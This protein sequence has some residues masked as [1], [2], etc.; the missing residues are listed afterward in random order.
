LPSSRRAFLKILAA[1]G[2]I[3]VTRTFWRSRWAIQDS[4]RNHAGSG[5]VPLRFSARGASWN[6]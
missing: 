5:L 4:R 3:G 2:E 1:M 6:D